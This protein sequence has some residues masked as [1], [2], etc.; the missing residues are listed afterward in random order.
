MLLIQASEANSEPSQVHKKIVNSLKVIL[1]PYN[2][3]LIREYLSS[4]FLETWISDLS[5]PTDLKPKKYPFVSYLSITWIMTH[6]IQGN[7][8][9]LSIIG[10]LDRSF[11]IYFLL[12][13][14]LH[15]LP[16]IQ[17]R[18][19]SRLVFS[20]F[21]N[22]RGNLGNDRWNPTILFSWNSRIKASEKPMIT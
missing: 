6:W 11:S 20:R 9:I 10:S 4:I 2:S 5:D 13:S 21:L 22:L 16:E 18:R 7:S 3:G 17:C 19:N 12:R 14:V 1:K 15:I 8:R